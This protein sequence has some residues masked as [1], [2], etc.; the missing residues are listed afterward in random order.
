MRAVLSIYLLIAFA[1]TAG[2]MFMEYRSEEQRLIAQVNHLMF[3]FSPNFS[4][5]LWDLNEIQLRGTMRGVMGNHEVLGIRLIDI[6]DNSTEMGLL[7]HEGELYYRK[8]VDDKASFDVDNFIHRHSSSVLQFHFD[9]DYTSPR[10]STERVGRVEIFSSRRIIFDKVFYT[11]IITLFS[12]CIKTLSLWLIFSLILK[13]TVSLPLNKISVLMQKFS[14]YLDE[15]EKS[16]IKNEDSAG[17]NELSVLEKS[18]SHMAEQVTEQRQ[19]LLQ[20]QQQLEEAVSERTQELHQANEKLLKAS[21][22]QGRFFASI[23]HEIRTPIN[24]VIG[25]VD[26]LDAG[27]LSDEQR[28]QLALVQSSGQ[29]LQGIINDVLDYSKIAAGKMQIELIA[30]ELPKVIVEIENLFQQKVLPGVSFFTEIDDNTPTFI[31]SDPLRLRQI[32]INLLSNAFKFTQQGRVVLSVQ[33]LTD[34]AKPLLQF[35]VS[36]SGIGLTQEQQGKVFQAFSQAESHT[37]R[38]YGGTGLGLTICKQLLKLLQGDISVSSEPG[39]GTTF[40]FRLPYKSVQEQQ[41][42]SHENYSHDF[43]FQQLQV[44]VAEDNMTNIAVIKGLFKLYHIHADYVLDGQ[45]AVDKVKEQETTPFNLIFMDC[46]MPV[47]DGFSATQKIRDHER[48]SPAN[49]SSF[50]VALTS[51]ASH[52]KIEKALSS[53]MNDYLEKPLTRK[54]LLDFF[55]KHKLLL[56]INKG[57]S[58]R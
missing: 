29:L 19:Q 49:I 4:Q 18:Y 36:D 16:T 52:E 22:T 14:P 47:L 46:E 3:T 30:F 11:L 17:E 23:S 42:L 44:L 25:I 31:I 2:Q 50:I 12:A 51:H 28:H 5:A 53:G 15:D 32:L 57:S 34:N 24:A 21:E 48:N 43:V 35:S 20:H 1:V 40:S 13:K 26:V 27:E 9:I 38:Q 56:P 39:I 45:A 7:M 37:S 55:D 54:S 8:T 58:N 10:G 41:S 6:D 33:A